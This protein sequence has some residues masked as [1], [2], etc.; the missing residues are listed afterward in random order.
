ML[1]TDAGVANSSTSQLA[2]KPPNG[3]LKNNTNTS[4]LTICALCQASF[5]VFGF[6]FLRL[7]LVCRGEYLTNFMV[8]SH[9]HSYLSQGTPKSGKR[10]S[11]NEDDLILFFR[12]GLL[13]T[14]SNLFNLQQAHVSIYILYQIYSLL[15]CFIY[16]VHQEHKANIWISL[17]YCC[18]KSEINIYICCSCSAK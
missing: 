13:S 9:A 3:Q 2:V 17:V 1:L 11:E 16:Y 4:S 8:H 18:V 14:F 10:A 5:C 15:F 6:L 12:Q 7:S